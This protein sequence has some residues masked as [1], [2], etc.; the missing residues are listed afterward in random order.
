MPT[1]PIIRCVCIQGSN[2]ITNI[3]ADVLVYKTF[4]SL[5]CLTWNRIL[6]GVFG[7]RL[8]TRR[9]YQKSIDFLQIFSKVSDTIFRVFSFS[10]ICFRYSKSCSLGIYQMA[11]PYSNIGTICLSKRLTANRTLI[12]LFVFI[13]RK[14]TL[15]ILLAFECRSV[16]VAF[17][18]SLLEIW[19]PR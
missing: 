8:P 12:L 16:I 4:L 19:K 18:L 6:R 9:A 2:M 3:T 13:A 7:S 14:I 5:I 10:G 1:W 15:A 11:L 17:I